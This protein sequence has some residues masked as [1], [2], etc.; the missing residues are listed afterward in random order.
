MKLF[1]K[2]YQVGTKVQIQE[3][4]EYLEITKISAC[5]RLVKVGDKAYQKSQVF[6]STNK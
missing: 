2:K 1:T 3:G 5:R 6:K 4:G